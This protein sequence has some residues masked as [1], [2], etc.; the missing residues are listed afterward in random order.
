MRKSA[1]MSTAVLFVCFAQPGMHPQMA[2]SHPYNVSQ[3]SVTVYFGAPGN[4]ADR[5]VA[6]ANF[7]RLS[8]DRRKR[9]TADS[10]KLLRLA[11][12]LKTQLDQGNRATQPEEAIRK[13]EE[14]AKLAHA[15]R[16]KMVETF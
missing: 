11:T 8:A 14:I 2:R 16:E 7:K 13:A 15:I 9:I 3:S 1:I 4:A 6:R 5:A 10:L 12:D